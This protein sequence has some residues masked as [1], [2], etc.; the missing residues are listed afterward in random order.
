MRP[1]SPR[2]GVE[3]ESQAEGK[4]ADHGEEA[5]PVIGLHRWRASSGTGDEASDSSSSSKQRQQQLWQLLR[6]ARAMGAGWSCLCQTTLPLM[7]KGYSALAGQLCI[8]LSSF[9][10]ISSFFKSCVSINRLLFGFFFLSFSSNIHL[11]SHA[12]FYF[13]LCCLTSQQWSAL[14]M[15]VNLYNPS[16]YVK[17]RYLLELSFLKPQK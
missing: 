12:C 17:M 3:V 13:M 2:Q 7:I 6:G 4:R 10:N 11:S 14:L 16:V 1:C 9:I 5:P 8:F 15:L